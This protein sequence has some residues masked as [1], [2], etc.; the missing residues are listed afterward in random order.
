MKS[1][2]MDHEIM[3]LKIIPSD[4][5]DLEPGEKKVLNML[6]S[7]Y[8]TVDYTNYLYI[9]PRLK[10]LN[11]DFLLIDVYKGICIIEVK[12]W[13]IGYIKTI[14]NSYVIDI[15]DR[16]IN[17][18]VFRANQYFNFAKIRILS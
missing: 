8:S 9:Q 12:D 7:I 1:N 4:I 11:P 2:F 10:K 6:N 18:P 5:S 14:N 13:S 16:R 3:S 15:K 17:N